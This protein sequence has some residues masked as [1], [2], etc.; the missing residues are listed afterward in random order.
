MHDSSLSWLDTTDSIKCGGVKLDLWSQA[1]SVNEIMRSCKV[2]FIIIKVE[3]KL[4]HMKAKFDTN[5]YKRSVP[6]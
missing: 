5:L 1:F 4:A 3:I 2:F 6:H